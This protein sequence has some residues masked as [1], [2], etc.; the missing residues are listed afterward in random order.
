MACRG[1]SLCPGGSFLCA[2]AE[3][4]QSS[5]GIADR[6]VNA[7]LACGVLTAHTRRPFLCAYPYHPQ[8]PHRQDCRS[9]YAY[10]AKIILKPPHPKEGHPL[11]Q[12]SNL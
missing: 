3:Q 9:P 5:E 7:F 4:T 1:F 2:D 8:H 12:Y 10:K 6:K 11:L